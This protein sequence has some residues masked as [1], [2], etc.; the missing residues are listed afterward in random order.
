MRRI[1]V[2]HVYRYNFTAQRQ[3]IF[4]FQLTESRESSFISLQCIVWY[5]LGGN[6]QIFH[7]LF[8][9]DQMQNFIEISLLTLECTK[10]LFSL[11]RR[12]IERERSA[13]EA[14]SARLVQNPCS[15]ALDTLR[16]L[17]SGLEW[18]TQRI[19]H[20]DRPLS[21]YFRFSGIVGL[22]AVLFSSYDELKRIF[23]IQ[24][25]IEMESPRGRSTT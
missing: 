12:T 7:N 9:M 18:P 20:S 2:L 5:A 19:W 8:W 22:L 17:P 23:L 25:V 4:L 6:I 21:S 11:L 10:S 13:I 14:K 1:N 3:A 16:P 24:V 15:C